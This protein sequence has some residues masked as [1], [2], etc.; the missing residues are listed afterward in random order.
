[1]GA[2]TQAKRGGSQNHNFDPSKLSSTTMSDPFRSVLTENSMDYQHHDGQ[3]IGNSPLALPTSD[4][5]VVLSC[6]SSGKN[7]STE[8]AK[9]A[10]LNLHFSDYPFQSFAKS[11]LCSASEKQA[12][13]NL[14]FSAANQGLDV[15]HSASSRQASSLK[16]RIRWT[17]D[18]HDQ[19]VSCVNRLGG[20]AKA[21]PKAILKLMKSNSL[22]IYHVKSHLQKYRTGLY[23]PE[24]VEGG[25]DI[26]NVSMAE[27][28][29]RRTSENN[30]QVH[31][32]IFL[33]ELLTQIREALQL[34]LEV[35]RRLHDQFEVQKHLQSLIEQQR[36]QLKPV[37]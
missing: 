30:D 6:E 9:Q 5:H 8:S 20:P 17:K 15:C 19:F 23:V 22:T 27:L 11:H 35:E 1:M 16:K 2:W 32:K 13:S 28:S 31:L 36:R 34:Q 26:N 29:K 37:V 21:T 7:F 25:F 24:S 10:G 12:G 14:N 4:S 18:L 3:Q 33:N